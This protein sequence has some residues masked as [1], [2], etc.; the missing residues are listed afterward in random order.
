M[1]SL[2]TRSLNTWSV[3]CLKK[4]PG[5]QWHH[6]TMSQI[7]SVYLSLIGK[8]VVQKVEI[9]FLTPIWLIIMW[10]CTDSKM[11]LT[12]AQYVTC[13]RGWQ[14]NLTYAWYVASSTQKPTLHLLPCSTHIYWLKDKRGLMSANKSNILALVHVT[15]VMT[16]AF[17]EL[18]LRP[19]IDYLSSVI[20]PVWHGCNEETFARFHYIIIFWRDFI[21][22]K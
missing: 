22:E 12:R 5:M 16:S 10:D 13:T 15:R 2:S 20:S 11:H 7:L 19:L 17:L 1:S 9:A 3:I 4:S 6:M 21:C 14:Q 18:K 8:F